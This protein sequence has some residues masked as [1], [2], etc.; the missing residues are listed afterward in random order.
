MHLRGGRLG[1]LPQ[2]ETRNPSRPPSQDR[3]SR[4]E[5]RLV[6]LPRRQVLDRCSSG[7]RVAHSTDSSRQ[8]S[9]HPIVGPKA[10]QSLMVGTLDLGKSFSR[11]RCDGALHSRASRISHEPRI[12][13]ECV[14]PTEVN[15]R[16][17]SLAKEGLMLLRNEV[18]HLSGPEIL[19]RAAKRLG[20]RPQPCFCYDHVGSKRL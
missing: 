14:E 12:G 16:I 3:R 1:G 19:D 4:R 17:E 9:S 20:K 18:G 7:R 15:G 5:G 13:Q 2:T 11:D 10:P 6:R 8:T